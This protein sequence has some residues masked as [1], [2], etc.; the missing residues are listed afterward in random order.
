MII[1]PACCRA[2]TAECLSCQVGQTV[3]EYCQYN[4]QTVGCKGMFLLDV[5]SN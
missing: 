4:P 3:E 2:Y 5:P 1:A